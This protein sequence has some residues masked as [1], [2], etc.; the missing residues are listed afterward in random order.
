MW[1]FK[2]KPKRQPKPKGKTDVTV[3]GAA[4]KIRKRNQKRKEILDQL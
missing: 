2:D 4:K 3:E 1:P